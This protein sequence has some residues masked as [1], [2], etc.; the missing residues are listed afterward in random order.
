MFR[1]TAKSM[2]ASFITGARIGNPSLVGVG[3]WPW[4]P[5]RAKECDVMR[6]GQG[7]PGRFSNLSIAK[8]LSSCFALLVVGLVVVVVVGSSGM[9]SMTAVHSDVVNVGVAKQLAAEDARSAASDM[10]FSQ[11]LYV[12]G[13]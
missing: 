2:V 12:L 5:C 10:H 6:M 8:K 3:L 9:S 1:P 11:T 13:G 4:S 7:L